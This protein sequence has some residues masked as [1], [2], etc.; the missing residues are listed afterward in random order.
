MIRIIADSAA[1]Y[2]AIENTKELTIVPL[3][4]NLDG[5]E[6]LDSVTITPDEFY[7]KLLTTKDFPKTSCPSPHSF[8]EAMKPGVE[9][10][11]EILVVALSSGIS[12][13]VGSANVAAKMF[14]DAKITVYDTLQAS[15][16][17]RI[18][19]DLAVK[20][21]KEG[22][23]VKEIVE[24]LDEVSPRVT[25]LTLVDDLSYAV[26]GG[27]ISKAKAI[28]GA[29]ARVKSMVNVDEKGRARNNHSVIGRARAYKYLVKRFNTL[30]IDKTFPLYTAYTDNSDNLDKYMEKINDKIDDVEIIKGRWGATVGSHAGKSGFGVFYVR[31]FAKEESFIEKIKESIEET[32]EQLE[33]RLK[34]NK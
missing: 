7:S 14:E 18:L 24:I 29:L 13:T 33:E 27:R 28:V 1:D 22:K 6:Y 23:T 16:G 11:D 10:G 3:S 34:R 9:A 25:T 5:K 20:L 4:I 31:K 30:E 12:G 2:G 19:V 32:K 8:Y 17:E 26:K 21:V 15:M